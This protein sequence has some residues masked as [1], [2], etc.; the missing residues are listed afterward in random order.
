MGIHNYKVVDVSTIHIFDHL[1]ES[2]DI[3]MVLA[4]NGIKTMG[5]TVKNEALED[6]YLNLT[7]GGANV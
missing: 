1:T 7:G 3:T 6:Y 4:E 2:G 5:I